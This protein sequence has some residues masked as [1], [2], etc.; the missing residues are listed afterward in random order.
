MVKWLRVG[1]LILGTSLSPSL[2]AAQTR[3]TSADVTG[4]VMDESKGVL[5]GATVTAT[6]AET[7][8]VRSVVTDA[9][10]RFAIPALPPGTYAVTTELPGF[11]TQTRQGIVLQLGTS[12]AVDFTLRIAGTR[13]EITVT[14]A[15]SE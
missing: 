14:A 3:A 15:S 1:L 12:V 10:G 2:A 5:P 11:A 6:N 4:V 7:N 8:L 13:E 9:I